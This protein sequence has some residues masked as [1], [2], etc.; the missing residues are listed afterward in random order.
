MTE[1]TD[2]TRRRLPLASAASGGCACCAPAAPSTVGITE[3]AAPA[4]STTYQVE[5][6]TC[7]HCAGRVTDALTALD[8]VA[9]VRVELV[10]GGTSGVVVT[11]SADAQVVRDAVGRAGYTVVAS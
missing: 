8:D 7:G 2:T 6:M 1:Q 3:Q 10:A 11:G 5:G 9:D 4:A